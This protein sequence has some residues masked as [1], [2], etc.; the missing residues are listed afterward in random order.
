MVAL[1]IRVLSNQPANEIVNADLGFIKRIGLMEHL[2]PTRANG[3]V[4]MIK[5]MKEEAF[6]LN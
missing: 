6:K 1:M 3:L 5:K 2:S 4:S